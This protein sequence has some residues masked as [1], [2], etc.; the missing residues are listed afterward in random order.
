MRRES[1]MQDK[2][3][4]VELFSR[5]DFPQHLKE[6]KKDLRTV[7]DP[8]K[9]FR[10]VKKVRKKNAMIGFQKSGKLL[11]A[12]YFFSSCSHRAKGSR[13]IAGLAAGSN[14]TC[15]FVVSQ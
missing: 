4:E 13:R 12:L 6:R 2:Y 9:S 5:Q 10:R 11:N 15:H 7:G 1:A 8:Q 14:S 3:V